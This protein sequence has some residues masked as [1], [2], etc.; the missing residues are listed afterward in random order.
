VRAADIPW[1]VVKLPL[2]YGF[3]RFRVWIQSWLAAGWLR[4]W[5]AAPLA[6]KSLIAD[7]QD[8]VQVRAVGV[9]WR[10]MILPLEYGF[11]GFVDWLQKM[12]AGC[13]GAG[14]Q[15]HWQ[16]GASLKTDKTRYR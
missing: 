2:K 1:R 7:R 3:Q 13:C 5:L 16:I 9:P 11:L 6:D 15:H 4:R 10:V 14:W 8:A 12:V